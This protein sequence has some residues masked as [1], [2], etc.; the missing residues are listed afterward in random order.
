MRLID[1]QTD[2]DTKPDSKQSEMKIDGYIGGDTLTLIETNK[3]THH[4]HH[5]KQ[6]Y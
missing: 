1:K 3:N 6:T 4:R 2:T 5:K